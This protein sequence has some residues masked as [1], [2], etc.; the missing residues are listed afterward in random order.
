MAVVGVVA[1]GQACAQRF[2]PR[3]ADTR[4]R[5]LGITLYPLDG[6]PW[7]CGPN[8]R[9]LPAQK[10]KFDATNCMLEK[11][12][13]TQVKLA[14]RFTALARDRASEVYPY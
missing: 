8:D 1:F 14:P 13:L 3:V 11:Q 7:Y 5:P 4:E 12:T 2:L 9:C 6:H 10:R